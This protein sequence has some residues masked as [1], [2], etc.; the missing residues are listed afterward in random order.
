MSIHPSAIISPDA[1]IGK[2]VEIGPF[3]VVE[4][5]VTLGDNCKLHSHV[6]IHGQ[7]KIGNNNEFFPFAAIGIKSQDLK[8]A[9]EP[10]ALEV[11]DRNVFRENV[12]IH[13]GTHEKL[14]TRIGNDNLILAYAHVAHDCQIANHNILSNNASLAGHVET[15][16]YVIVSGLSGVHQFCRLGAHA[17]I[18]GMTK[19]T[20]D[21]PPFTIIDGNPG[22]VRGINKIGLERRGFSEEDLRA[23]KTAY[24]KLFFRKDLNLADAIASLPEDAATHPRVKQLVD[25][26]QTSKRGVMR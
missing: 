19:I 18:G 7:S 4:G 20:Q 6:V 25:F 8:Y 16:D 3:C 5:N 2:N 21:I 9:G 10:T 22:Q 13:R 15:E 24:K 26:I 14:P 11:G 23:L 12:T 17:I 1:Q